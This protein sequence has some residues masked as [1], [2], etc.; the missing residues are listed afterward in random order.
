MNNSKKKANS[1]ARHARQ[2]QRKPADKKPRAKRA[3]NRDNLNTALWLWCFPVGLS[4][5][6]RARCTWP[7]AVKVGITAAMA[8][9]LL[10]VFI[11]PTPGGRKPVTGVELVKGHPEGEVYGPAL[12]AGGVNA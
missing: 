3:L 1:A 12:P 5:L 9:I 6:W 10:A 2:P 4:K 11:V 8:A 7:K